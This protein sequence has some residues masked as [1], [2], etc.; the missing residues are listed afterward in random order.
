MRR[1]CLIILIIIASA[2]CE[3]KP[4]VTQKE[5][6]RG[7]TTE[8]VK[9]KE[10]EDYIEIP[11]TI[12]AKTVSRV[13]SRVMGTV[14]AVRVKDGDTVKEGDILVTIDDRELKE[15]LKFAEASLSEALS[16]MEAASQR[17]ELAEKTFARYRNLYE[18]KA[19]SLQE[20]DEITAQRNVAHQQW[21]AA[22]SAAERARA[23]VA[24]AR[25]ALSY[26][27]VTSPV[28]GVVSNKEVEEG[29]FVL[30]GQK[31]LDVED[32]TNF[33]VEF[34]A[35][36]KLLP[37][38]SKGT[39]IDVILPSINTKTHGVVTEIVPSIDPQTRSFLVKASL[40]ETGLKTGMYGRVLLH[41]G[42]RWALVVPP[43][44]IVRRGQLTGVF[45]EDESGRLTFR[46]VR[47]GKDYK[48]G[49]EVISGLKDGERIV[50]EGTEK[51][52]DGAYID[53]S[54]SD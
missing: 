5:V 3:E 43:D 19:I 31:L 36:E 14:T 2:G 23:N 47:T 20:M 51:A 11:G 17:R 48:E 8:E 42:R 54:V 35:D 34:Y 38:V 18:E 30:A 52:I 10:V 24:Q 53:K 37:A 26:A 13:A 45:V 39:G 27:R 40:G 16:N 22:R 25:V 28:S 29:S 15:A 46:L 50:V 41:Y 44:S 12:R 7:L 1:A 32:T 21:Q 9:L 49:V 33:E 6:V 4:E